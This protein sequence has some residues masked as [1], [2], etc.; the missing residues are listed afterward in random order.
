VLLIVLS[1]E[2]SIIF[3][4][5]AFELLIFVIFVLIFVLALLA[6]L[7]IDR[8]IFSNLCVIGLHEVFLL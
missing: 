6:I 7:I 8:R 1:V 5:K 4:D 2:I 3:I